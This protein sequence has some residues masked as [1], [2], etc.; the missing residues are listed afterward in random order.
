MWQS[1][2]AIRRGR[3][4][5]ACGSPRPVLCS[6]TLRKMR[7]ETPRKAMATAVKAKR[8]T[9]DAS[10]RGSVEPRNGFCSLRLMVDHPRTSCS[11]DVARLAHSS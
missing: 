11:P 8:P 5:S 7:D 10:W 3:S 4:G 9:R 2:S 6:T 1:H